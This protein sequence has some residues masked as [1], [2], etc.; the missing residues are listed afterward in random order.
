MYDVRMEPHLDLSKFVFFADV[1]DAGSFTMAGRRMQIDRSNISRGIK[2]LERSAGAQLL[3]RTTRKMVLTELGESFYAQ[4]LN[5]RN[6]VNQA[7]NILLSNAEYVRGPIHVSCPPALGRIFLLPALQEFCRLYPDVSVRITLKSGLI[8][9]IEE[10]V[11]VALRF[12]DE[13]EQNLVA[14]NLWT[15][16]WLVCA[17]PQYVKF[18]GQPESPDDLSL[19]AWIG[20]QSKV[21]LKFKKKLQR[22]RAMMSSRITCADYD[23]IGK[24]A[25]DGLGI[26]LLPGHVAIP[27][28]KEKKLVQV[29]KSFSLEATPGST[30][31]ALTL[32]GPHTPPQVKTFL[33]FIKQRQIDT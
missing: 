32:P 31:Y 9:L 2:D 17:S 22:Y 19:H 18:H 12:T 25:I 5:I 14:R 15:T 24:F 33:T 28:I 29:L 27:G 26:A 7:K 8:D 10:R 16:D 30:L 1:V 20:I 4:C 3:R 23:V 13:P 21:I 6:E 11:D